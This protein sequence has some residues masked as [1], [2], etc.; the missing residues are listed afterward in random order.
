ME[1]EGDE[2]R[3]AREAGRGERRR[4]PMRRTRL[5]RPVSMAGRGWE[6]VA[7]RECAMGREGTGV[8]VVEAPWSRAASHHCGAG[9]WGEG[10]LA[11]LVFRG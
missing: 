5:S 4:L 11:V 2:R 3:R 7:A 6:E 8:E 1:G 10:V 9:G